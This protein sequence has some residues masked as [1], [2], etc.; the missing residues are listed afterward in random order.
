[1]AWQSRRLTALSVQRVKEPGLYPDGDGL[2]LRVTPVGTK[3]WVLRFMLNRR[4]R[5]M[6][7]GPLKLYGLQEARANALDARRFDMM[8]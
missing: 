5:W 2:Y 4:P 3:N 1:M 6:G 8:G 7:L